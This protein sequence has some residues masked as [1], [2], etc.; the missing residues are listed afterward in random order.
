[1]TSITQHCQDNELKK[2]EVEAGRPVHSYL[3][4]W[5]RNGNSGVRMTQ[6]RWK[7]FLEIE[8][9]LG[10]RT[11]STYRQDFERGRYKGQ[12]EGPGHE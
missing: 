2:A 3:V 6:W 4:D 12:L 8:T 11:Y 5:A 7:Q 10:G 9:Y 1:M